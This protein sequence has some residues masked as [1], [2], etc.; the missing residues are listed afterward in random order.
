MERED[1]LYSG[2]VKKEKIEDPLFDE[3]D[4]D[5]IEVELID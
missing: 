4:E 3:P 2:L 5:S 1:I